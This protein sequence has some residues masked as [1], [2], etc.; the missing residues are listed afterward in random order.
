MGYHKRNNLAGYKISGH[1]SATSDCPPREQVKL[2]RDYI[3]NIPQ[4][5]K[6]IREEDASEEV[7]VIATEMS[8]LRFART[9]DKRNVSSFYA[10]PLMIYF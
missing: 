4:L 2:F 5:M 3:V 8:N 1:N 9:P 10:V 6:A 7:E